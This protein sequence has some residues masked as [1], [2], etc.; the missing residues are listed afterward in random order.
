MLTSKLGIPSLLLPQSVT[1]SHCRIHGLWEHQAPLSIGFSRQE[2]WSG[3]PLP[4]PGV[5]L[6]RGLNLGLQHCRQILYYL[7]H[8]G[9]PEIQSDLLVNVQVIDFL[10]NASRRVPLQNILGRLC[11]IWFLWP[12]VN[13][14]WNLR[15]YGVHACMLLPQSCLTLCDSMDCSLPGSS[16]HG[17]IL[18]ARIL[19]WTAMPSSRESLK[20]RD[21]TCAS[22]VSCI[23]RWALYH[24]G[25]MYRVGLQKNI[26]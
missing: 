15:M 19:E 18:Q 6:T 7:S 13:K 9:S 12:L 21:R 1:V 16:I 23:F 10:V 26:L 4:S 14:S 22:Y 24:L 8:Q 5:F 25:S 20:P 17:I 3:L 11:L 2:Y